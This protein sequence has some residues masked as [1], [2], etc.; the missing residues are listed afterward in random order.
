MITQ[1][2]TTFVDFNLKTGLKNF[3]GAEFKTRSI[4]S[5]DFSEVFVLEQWFS[6]LVFRG[7]FLW[8]N[9]NF[10][11]KKCNKIGLVFK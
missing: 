6:T 1:G 3:L 8:P 11:E 9:K 7:P 10:W 2:N 4:F 5:I